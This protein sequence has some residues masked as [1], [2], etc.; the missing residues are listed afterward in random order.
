MDHQTIDARP[1]KG[2][3]G[4]LEKPFANLGD[5]AMSETDEFLQDEFLQKVLA[6]QSECGADHTLQTPVHALLAAGRLEEAEVV[7][8]RQFLI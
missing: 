6:D 1:G 5:R 4:L 7:R 3:P 8:A 2:E